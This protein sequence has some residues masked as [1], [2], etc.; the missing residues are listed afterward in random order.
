MSRPD[1]NTEK[2]DKARDFEVSGGNIRGAFRDYFYHLK[3]FSRNVRLYLIGS[4]LIG[5]TFASYQLLLN[6]Y[7]R[8]QGMTESFIGLIL[9]RGALGMT[10]ISIPAALLLKKIRLK[11]ILII[12]TILYVA[13]IFAL[14]HLPIS[15]WLTILSLLA[16]MS[17]T[18]YRVAASPFFMRNTSPEERTYVFSSS[19][20]MMLLASMAGSMVFGKMAA[21]LAGYLGDGVAAYQYTFALSVLLGLSAVIPFGMIKATDPKDENGDD[22]ISWALLKKR[23]GLYSRLFFPSFM[24]GIGAGL[25]IPFLNIY[26]RDRFDLAPDTIG[27]YFSAVQ[28]TMLIGILAGPILVRKFGMIRAIVSTQLI[29]M[30][31]MV[32]LAFTEYLPLAV[33]AFLIRGALMNLGNPIGRNFGMEMVEPGEQGLVN[34]LMM[35]SWTGAWMFSTDIGGRLIEHYG[36]TIP[37]IIAV[38]LYMISSIMYYFFFRRSEVRTSEGYKISHPTRET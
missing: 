30:P 25:I 16:G 27:Y 26:F 37:L 29:S 21:F 35:V 23:S 33:A 24:T 19:F 2:S 14:T 11:P 15:S 9:S 20:G 10:L 3:L 8:E 5:L 22:K 32:V 13:A 18:F 1:Y 28:T 17:L 6:L 4:F 34:A 12:T 31:F 36:Y 38:G 7:L